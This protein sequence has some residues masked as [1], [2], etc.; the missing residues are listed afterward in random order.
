M[1]S[2]QCERMGQG[3]RA[4][5][6]RGARA[7]AHF[8]RATRL[9]ARQ[10]ARRLHARRR[11]A[12]AQ[13]LGHGGHQLREQLVREAGVVGQAV[14]QG[15]N[16]LAHAEAHGLV[17]RLGQRQERPQQL[18]KERVVVLVRLVSVALVGQNDDETNQPFHRRLALRAAASAAG[19]RRSQLA[20]P[21]LGHDESVAHE[22]QQLLG[23]LSRLVAA[24]LR[25][26]PRVLA[27]NLHR[28]RLLALVQYRRQRHARCE[29]RHSARSERPRFENRPTWCP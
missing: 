20:A 14:Q 17:R 11:S 8:K 16:Q 24:T 5:R 9:E 25:Q 2:D 22:A 27:V 18:L 3:R 13:P 15:S 6:R 7:L 10:R 26:Q 21:H 29:R 19:C 12:I 23:Q 28:H 4:K 1:V